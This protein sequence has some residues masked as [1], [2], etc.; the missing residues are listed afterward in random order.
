MIAYRNALEKKGAQTA[1]FGTD[2]AFK[3]AASGFMGK[4]WD[5]LP[6]VEILKECLRVLKPG[7]FALWLMTPRQDSQM[8]FLSRL[9]QAGF[10][11][12]FSSIYWAYASGFPK[13]G[14]VS[15]LVDRKLG[16]EREVIGISPNSRP[17]CEGKEYVAGGNKNC[18]EVPLFG[19][20]VT[21]AAA[22]NGSYCGF[23]P[24]PAVEVVIVSMKPLSEKTYVEQA[25]KNGKGITWLDDCRIPYI[26]DDIPK[27]GY[28][29]M[30]IGIGKPAEHQTYTPMPR[31]SLN[32]S[33]DSK[34]GYKELVD[35]GSPKGRFP[36]NLLDQR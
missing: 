34:W 10:T 24:K 5:V 23:Q 20:P 18:K 15:K 16:A 21:A 4:T 35:I 25:L 31:G 33:S 7:A 3:R 22:L 2:G 32:S 29:R 1:Q 13:A 11:I 28:G 6:S 14:N 12:G 17:N 26:T 19:N 9:R 8:E 27:G 36:A 30:D